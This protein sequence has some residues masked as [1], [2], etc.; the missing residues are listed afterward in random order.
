MSWDLGN[1]PH[2]LSPPLSL[3][4]PD[5]AVLVLLGHHR[6]DIVPPDHHTSTLSNTFNLDPNPEFWPHLDPDPYLELCYKF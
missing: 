4:L 5:P 1:I 2:S 3:S 6:D